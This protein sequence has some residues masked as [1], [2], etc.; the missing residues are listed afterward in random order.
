MEQ[1]GSARN[2]NAEKRGPH[3]FARGPRGKRVFPNGSLP[4]F[5]ATVDSVG[6]IRNLTDFRPSYI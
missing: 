1:A 4:I 6:L 2:C 3:A 5:E